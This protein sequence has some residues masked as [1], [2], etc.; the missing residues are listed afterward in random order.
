M[1]RQDSHQAID[2]IMDWWHAL[3]P[4]EIDGR[5]VPGD[6][7]GRAR[8]RRAETVAQIV[9]EPQ[10]HA[11]CQLAPLTVKDN[12]IAVLAMTLPRI[13]PPTRSSNAR[14]ATVLGQTH[15]GKIPGPDEQARLSS[16]R[17]GTL[18]RT[19]DDANRFAAALRRA[20]AILDGAPFNARAFIPDLLWFSD[21]TRRDWTFQYYQTWQARRSAPDDAAPSDTTE[22][23]LQEESA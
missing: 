22:P 1:T 14:F 10:F 18:L 16:M 7:G 11:L 17:F 4:R 3:F 13:V 2:D 20:I 19:S 9:L 8:L 6:N 21:T 12:R 15:D 5:T 23:P